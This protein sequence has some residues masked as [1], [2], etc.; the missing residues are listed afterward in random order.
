MRGTSLAVLAALVAAPLG[1]GQGKDAPH[2][3][4]ARISVEP[5]AFDFGKALPGKTLEKEFSIRNFGNEDHVIESVSTTCGCTVA[6]GYG[7]AIKP[8]AST[9]MRVRLETRSYSGRVE[10]SVLIK[11]NDP[12]RGRVEIRVGATVVSGP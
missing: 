2:A 12:V 7:K 1:A 6:D 10:R 11:T 4:G 5:A 9:S 3:G 8:G